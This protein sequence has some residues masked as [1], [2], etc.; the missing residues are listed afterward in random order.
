[1]KNRSL[2]KKILLALFALAILAASVFILKRNKAISES[3]VFKLDP[4]ESIGVGVDTLKLV[5]HAAPLVY[6][7]QFEPIRET[8]LSAEIPGKIS[9]LFVREGHTVRQGQALVVLDH[10]LLRIQKESVELQ[11]E[12][13]ETDVRRYRTLAAADA[14]QGIQLEKAELALRVAKIQLSSLEEQIRKNT[15]LAPF[16]GIITGLFSEEGAYA[17]PGIPILQLSDLSSVKL[18]AQVSDRDVAYFQQKNDLHITVDALPEKTW[19]GTVSMV[20]SKANPANRFP[21]QFTVA[22]TT[23]PVIRAGM[24]GQVHLKAREEQP[25]IRIPSYA[26]S[27]NETRRTVFLIR[28]GK[29][30][31]QPVETGDRIN[32]QIIIRSGLREGD[33]LI[34]SG[35]DLLSEGTRVHAQAAN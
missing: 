15:I 14:V 28:E 17:A 34:T 3:R 16:S 26:L 21:V 4:D 30:T 35:L 24:F 29:A 1:M 13:H 12:G 19:K 5:W 25:V 23:P 20:G 7:G 9:Q 33:V 18:T 22:N 8:K 11:I 32:D 31:A 10:A 27:G 2:F 6:T